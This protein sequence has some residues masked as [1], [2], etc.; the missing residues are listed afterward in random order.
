MPARRSQVGLPPQTGG[1]FMIPTELNDYS[2]L[3]IFL[4][5]IVFLV[6]AS[7]TGRLLG[8]RAAG[9]GGDDVSTL[10]AA[11][12]GLL[13]L[14]IGFTFAMALTRFDA[15]RD[16]V[17]NEANA[18]GTTALRARLLPAPHNV[19]TNKLLQEYVQTRLEI[20]QRVV[21]TTEL[22]AAIARWNEIQEALWQQ[23][24][25]VASQDKGVVPTGLF[26]LTLNEMID[27]QG[28]RLDAF[29][30]R[31]PNIVLLALYGVAIVASAFAGYANGLEARRVRLPIYLMALLVAAVI[32]LIQDLDRPSTGFVK[33]IQQPMI[34]VANSIAAYSD[35]AQYGLAV[36]ALLAPT[37]AALRLVA[38]PDHKQLPGDRK[39]N[40]SDKQTNHAMHERAAED[41]DE[42]YRHRRFQSF[43]YERS[44]YVVEQ[45]YWHHVEREQDRCG[46]L[47]RKPAPYD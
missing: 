14:M 27:N 17:V 32:L 3:T 45:I 25:I 31:V 38:C 22:N 12:L 42:Y 33:T 24:K 6:A 35:Q 30:N 10:E 36:S 43:S 15:R 34:D 39:H 46:R 29:R 20:T 37:S 18:I 4:V 2:L 23:A 11:I 13:A 7:E 21:S 44:Q 26:I 1:I 28:K 5:S 47:H 9:R 41:P 19:E 40:R 8:V 16:A